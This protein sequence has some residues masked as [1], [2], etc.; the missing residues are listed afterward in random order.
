MF[1][2]VITTTPF[3]DSDSNDFFNNKIWIGRRH[4][5][6]TDDKTFIST[7]RALIYPRMKEADSLSF[8][9]TT[10]ESSFYGES[11]SERD[12][13]SVMQSLVFTPSTDEIQIKNF[14]CSQEDGELWIGFAKKYFRKAYPSFTEVEKVSEFF[15]KSFP[16]LCFVDTNN[17][18]V[19]LFVANLTVAKLHYLQCGIFAFLP[20]YFDAQEGVSAEEM[21]LINSLRE[22]DESVYKNVLS[23]MAKKYDFKTLRL[24]RLLDGFEYAV[25][26]DMIENTEYEIRQYN[27]RMENIQTELMSILVKKEEL[28]AKILGVRQKI[29]ERKSSG[30]DGS[31]IIDYF[32]TN[33]KLVLFDCEDGRITFGVKDYVTYFDEDLAVK[34]I[35]NK[36]S[37]LYSFDSFSI[38][39]QQKLLKAVFIDK[40]IKFRVCAAYRIS[41][42]DGVRPL[43]YYSFDHNFD[44][45]TPNVHIDR[46]ACMGNNI[47]I[48]EQCLIKHDYIGA[49]DQCIASAKSLNFADSTVMRQTMCRINGRDTEHNS[50]KCFELPDGRVVTPKEA[51]IYLRKKEKGEV[52]E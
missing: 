22:K 25:E 1:K 6:F 13:K 52:N 26:N 16:A 51:I 50:E 40:E 33:K 36:S 15:K 30:S 32:A 34:Y 2:K 10:Y 3:Y 31:D 24:K 29:A 4:S 21:S 11:A 44:G 43:T 46:Y 20:W 9:G 17:R 35:T 38:E 23:E 27:A 8:R 41:A 47:P 18:S 42:R 28:E 39:N 7:L 37:F 14:V 48:V 45:Y 12:N 19:M 5:L 49:I